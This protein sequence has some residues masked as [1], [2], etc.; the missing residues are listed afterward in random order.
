MI[1]TRQEVKEVLLESHRQRRR[2]VTRWTTEEIMIVSKMCRN[3]I[4]FRQGVEKRTTSKAT[5]T[6]CRS[7]IRTM[8]RILMSLA[9]TSKES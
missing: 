9:N 8:Q 7:K 6:L 2:R 1:A 5:I 3:E 4:R